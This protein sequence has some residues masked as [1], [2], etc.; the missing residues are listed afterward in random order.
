MKIVLKRILGKPKLIV[1]LILP[2]RQDK[3]KRP[4][5]TDRCGGLAEVW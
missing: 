5:T 2:R 4:P 3:Q 1:L